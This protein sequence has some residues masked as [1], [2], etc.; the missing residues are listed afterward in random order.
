[1][2]KE[3]LKFECRVQKNKIKKKLR[4]KN[5]KWKTLRKFWKFSVFLNLCINVYWTV[6]FVG[7]VWD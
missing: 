2:S 5:G 7:F 3:K 6:G 1:M 4:K